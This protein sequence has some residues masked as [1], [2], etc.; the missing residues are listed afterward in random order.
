MRGAGLFLLVAGLAGLAAPASAAA[1][2]FPLSGFDRVDLSGV[3]EV[4]VHTGAGFAVHAEG[5]PDAVDALLVEK[6]GTVLVVGHKPG[7]HDIRGRV[8]VAVSL[9]RLA[10]VAVSGAGSLAVD[11]VAAPDFVADLGGTGTLRLPAVAVERLRVRLSGAGSAVLAGR[12]GRIDL[13]LSGTGSIDAR[14]LK[15]GGGRLASS[16]VGSIQAQVDGPVDVNASGIGSIKVG[17]RPACTVHRSGMASVHC[18]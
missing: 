6:R 17:G 8:R 3:A 15:A 4:A 5:D 11:R 1:R 12:A 14:A 18:G 16:G 9:P 2:D 10:A 7:A 13:D